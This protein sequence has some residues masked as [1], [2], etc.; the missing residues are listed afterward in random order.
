MSLLPL[1]K[2][3]TMSSSTGEAVPPEEADI[4]AGCARFGQIGHDLADDAAELEA[5]T[6]EAGGEGDLRIERVPIDDEVLVRAVGKH[7]DFQGHRR[8]GAVGKVTLGELA[9]DR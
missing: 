2:K 4:V 1:S 7:A 5:V 8:A 3:P 6:G 9:Q